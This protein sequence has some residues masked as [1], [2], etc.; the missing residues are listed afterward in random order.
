MHKVKKALKNVRIIIV[1]VFIILAIVAIN[2]APWVEGVAI[3]SVGKNSSASIAGIENTKPSMPP[4]SREII[5][6]MNNRPITSIEEY[7]NFT[8]SLEPNRTVQIKTNKGVYR[9]VTRPLYEVIY[10]NETETRIV[11]EIQQ[12]NETVNG[13]VVSVNKTVQK[14]VQAQKTD[15]KLIGTEDIGLS[16]Y[17]APKN[18][19]RKGLDLQ[20]GTRVLLKP[21]KELEASEMDILLSN[22][23]ERLNVYG[24]SDVIVRDTSDLSGNQYVLVEI[25]G[26]NEEEV[27]EL[28]AKQGKFEAKVANS[29]VFRGGGDITYVCRSAECSGIDP[30]Q[31]CGKASDGSWVCRFRFSISLT[32]EAAQ[33][34]ADAT[35]NLDIITESGEQ[36]LSEKI[37]LFLDNEMVDSL[38]IG[39][40][41]KGRPVTDI[42]I[43]GAGAGRTREEAVYDALKN[44]KRLQTILITG[45][46][47]VKLDIIETNNISPVLGEEF[48]KNAIFMGLASI[49][50]VAIVV[51]IRYRKFEV[52][53]PMILTMSSEILLLLG[54]ASLVGWNLDLAAIAGIIV[55]A[56]TGVDDQI[57]IADEIL[58]GR[59]GDISA[60]WK[61]KIKMAFFI[62][63][64]AYLTVVVAMIP[65][66]FAG[67]GMLKGFAFTTIA[68]ISFGV[69]ITRPAYAAFIEIL[70][71][72]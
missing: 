58:R 21:E 31:G 26:A 45:S 24:L 22:M 55:A 15:L 52:A 63:M 39:A 46:L 28:L 29:T 43:S 42:S 57:V 65:L 60:G 20:G 6:A 68:G 64:G 47:P 3:R 40:E 36:Y 5:L 70:L 38:N 33:R 14:K 44:M 30:Q 35:T 53:M 27:K 41:L 56:G 18:N 2:P 32:P 13:T 54:L 12:V 9:L 7:K 49:L 72:E 1:L 69:F 61:Q 10:L 16:V 25:A 23:K 71:K 37:Y 8:S 67:A 48:T 51:F 50:A 4:R 17:N 19:I 34:Q 62:I 11:E 59:T 66:L